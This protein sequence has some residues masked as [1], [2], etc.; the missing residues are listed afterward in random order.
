MEEE[1][2]KEIPGFEGRYEASTLGRVRSVSRDVP[3]KGQGQMHMTGRVLKQMLGWNKKYLQVNLSRKS[4]MVHHLIAKTFLGERPATAVV[5]H[6]DGDFTN[7]RLSN[8]SYGTQSEN[9]QDCYAYGGRAG[10]GILSRED[11]FEIRSL[12]EAG[13]TQKEIGQRFGIAQTT[14]SNIKVGKTFNYL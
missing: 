13:V 8:L 12:L 3:R 6:L 5:R 1:I 9:L 7:N 2:W 11:V 14:V 10:Q 4:F